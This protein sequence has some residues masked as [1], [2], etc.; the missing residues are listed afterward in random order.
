MRTKKRPLLFNWSSGTQLYTAESP[1]DLQLF[2]H[3]LQIHLPACKQS[4]VLKCSLS[5]DFIIAS[6]L[7][8]LRPLLLRLSLI[9]S[10]HPS[11]LPS[12]PIHLEGAGVWAGLVEP[13]SRKVGETSDLCCSFCSFSSSVSAPPLPPP[14]LSCHSPFLLFLLLYFLVP[15]PIH[16]PTAFLLRCPLA[17]PSLPS[18]PPGKSLH[19]AGV[20][21]TS[22]VVMDGGIEHSSSNSRVLSLLQ[23]SAALFQ[24][25]FA[26]GAQLWP[27]TYQMGGGGKVKG[28]RERSAVSCTVGSP[29][30]R[31]SSRK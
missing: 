6:S 26:S 21:A 13:L 18:A 8:C 10:I 28:K 14:P 9:P 17:P 1:W 27:C 20:A 25:S 16:F 23:H 12:A 4:A 3:L 2:Q 30:G 31:P 5:F 15:P 7:F 24:H 19:S 22:A 11:F 29:G